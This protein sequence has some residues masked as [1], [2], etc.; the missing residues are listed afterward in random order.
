MT[1]RV[2]IVDIDSIIP[3][4]ALMQIS[5]HHKQQGDIVGFDIEDPDL[6][7]ISCIFSKNASLAR[8]IQT[9]YPD[10]D[11]ILGGS[12]FYDV[13]NLTNA[14]FK[15]EIPV[16]AQKIKPDYSLYPKAEYDLGFTTRGCFRKC[17][18]CIVREKEG[19]IH[20]WQHI[21]E[22]HDPKHKI[23]HLLDNN[24]YAIR[25]WFFE[26][27]DYCINNNLKLRVLPGFDIRILTDEIAA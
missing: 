26:N 9:L 6:I 20:K 1:R 10:A 21:S 18:F 8:G 22:F 15:R 17:P 2:R 14:N 12:G 4:L 7:Y 24:I 3:N 27:T 25:D 5:A 13:N 23:V 16:S 11:V 19:N